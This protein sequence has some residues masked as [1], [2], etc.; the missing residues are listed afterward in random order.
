MKTKYAIRLPATISVLLTHETVDQALMGVTMKDNPLIM[1][2]AM[3]DPLMG[4]HMRNNPLKMHHVRIM[5]TESLT[6]TVK[7]REKY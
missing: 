6:T 7:G 1:G 2:V 5:C 3:K 4:A